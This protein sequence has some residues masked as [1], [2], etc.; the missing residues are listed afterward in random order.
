MDDGSRDPDRD[1]PSIRASDN[2]REATV[3]LLQ[4]SYAEGRLTLAE[5]DERTTQ[6]YGARFQTDLAELTRDLVLAHRPS[7]THPA[8]RHDSAPARRVS[9]QTGPS[10][11]LAIMSGCERGGPWTVPDGH[12]TVAV[13]GGVELDLRQASLQTHELTIRAFSFMGGIE[14]VIPDDVHV[15]IDG[16]GIM[17]YFGEESNDGEKSRPVRQAPPGA[18]R[19][20]V[21]GLAVWAG[22]AVRR[23]PRDPHAN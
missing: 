4:D 6:A 2:E 20:R 5:F 11:S 1:L 15:D 23:V 10:T 17:G 9:G 3:Q 16:V 14:I 22:I 12:T 13:M 21:T 7:G 18:P 19:I 8:P